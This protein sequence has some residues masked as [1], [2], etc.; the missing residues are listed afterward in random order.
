MTG[1]N[2]PHKL[3]ADVPAARAGMGGTRGVGGRG[4]PRPEAS[5]LLQQ[6]AT[7]K[8][9]RLTAAQEKDLA[10]AMEKWL[11]ATGGAARPTIAR[12]ADLAAANAAYEQAVAAALRPQQQK[13]LE[14]L[15]IRQELRGQ[16]DQAVFQSD[17]AAKY[18]GLT[19]DQRQK[20]EGLVKERGESLAALLGAADDYKGLEA[21]VT[22]LRA[23]T[24]RK[25]DALLTPAQRA[26][27]DELL[28]TWSP[29]PSPEPPARPRSRRSSC[30]TGRSSPTSWRPS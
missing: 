28:G 4:A 8:E 11:E 24:R 16:N 14:R 17:R 1:A 22:T 7:V 3:T 20:C 5:R 6:P 10:A 9:L 23:E 18:L 27:R 21:K 25:V 30:S 12:R 15:L 29:E 13:H 26:G 19:D 2:F